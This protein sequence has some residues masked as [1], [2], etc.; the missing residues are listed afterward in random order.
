V[1]DALDCEVLFFQQ[2]FAPVIEALC[3]RLPKIRL[4][5]CID[6]DLPWAPSLSR[7]IE[8]QPSTA[9]VIDYDMDDVVV[10]SS[11][12]GTTGAPKGV[13]NMHR[14]FQ[15]FFEHFMMAFPYGAERPVN[16]AAAPMTDAAGGLALP[17][18][19]RGG[20]VVVLTRPDPAALLGAI[21][22]HRVTEFFLSPTVIYRLLDFPGIGAQDF[23]SRKYLIYG[24][25]PMSVD[26]LKRG[27][28]SL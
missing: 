3:E 13:M 1:L 20:T 10:L 21:A 11:A 16:L 5:V 17:C 26:K 18:T 22:R 6:A 27:A 7:W 2:A 4:W 14:S 12:G 24:T 15:T 9:P 23:S 28:Q 25:A 19:A 8:G